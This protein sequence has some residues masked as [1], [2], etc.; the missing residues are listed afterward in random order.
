[1]KTLTITEIDNLE[2]RYRAQLINCISGVKSIN[3]IGSQDANGQRNLAIFS[4]VIHLGSNPPLVGFVQRPTS[5]QRHTYENIVATNFYTINAV[6]QEIAM[7]A[8]QTSAR[9][10]KDESE[11]VETSL[12]HEYL[13]G[14][15]APFVKD[16]PLKIGLKLED[17]IPIP[18]NNTKLI[19]GKVEQLHFDES[20]LEEDG[21]LRLEDS[22]IVGGAGLDTY[23]KT[24][25]HGRYSYAKPD[26][27]LKQL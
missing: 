8:H 21:H 16:T 22:S 6:T 15:S 26:Q 5:V 10:N 7:Q 25:K 13:D 24:T 9:Y 12:E 3:L 14:F 23:L 20:L 11:F 27:T 1:M 19:I 17:I 18:A 4:S 2:K